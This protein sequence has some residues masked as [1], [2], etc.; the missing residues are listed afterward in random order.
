MAKNKNFAQPTSSKPAAAVVTPRPSTRATE[1]LLPTLEA[2]PRNRKIVLAIL[3]VCCLVAYIP[4]FE[5]GFVWDD[6]IY[7]VNN[8]MFKKVSWENFK[9]IWTI[10]EGFVLGNFHPLTITSNYLEYMLVGENAWLYHFNNTLLHIANSYLVYRVTE[11]ISKNFLVGAITGILFACHPLHV[12]SVVWAAERKDVLYTFFLL[13]SFRQYLKYTDHLAEKGLEWDIKHRDLWI[14]LALFVLSCLSK[15]MAVVLPVVLVMTDYFV[16]GRKQ[17]MKIGMEKAAFFGVALATGLVSIMAQR[18]A[19][20][21]ATKVLSAA[22]TGTERFFIIHYGVLQYWIKMILPVGLLPFYPYPQKPDNQLPSEF[23]GAFFIILMLVGAFWFFGRRNPLIAWSG[24][25]FAI[26]ILP[27]SQALPVGSAIAADRYFYVS[28]VGPLMLL[29]L[30]GNYLYRKASFRKSAPTVAAVV[31]LAFTFLS[32]RQATIWKDPLTLFPRVLEKYP[33][34]PLMVS[35]MGWYYFKE[36]DMKQAKYYFELTHDKGNFKTTDSHV[37]LGQIYFDEQNYAKTVEHF[38][39]AIKLKPEDFEMK[40]LRWMLATAYYYVGDLEKAKAAAEYS[41]KYIP[42]NPFAINVLGLIEVKKGNLAEAE[43][44]Y[45]QAIKANDKF[46]DPFVNMSVIYNQRGEHDKEIAILEKAVKIKDEKKTT[47]YKNLGV[48]YKAAGQW[49]KCIDVWK[50]GS[51]LDPK[52]GSFDYNIAQVYGQNQNEAEG[53]KFMISAVEKNDANA[54]FVVNQA[55]FQGMLQAK[56]PDLFNRLVQ[57][58][59]ARQAAAQQAQPTQ[60]ANT[61]AGTQPVGTPVQIP[62]TLK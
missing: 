56:Y 40:K 9:T 45:N 5:N 1:E 33:D 21:D 35:N 43:K 7:I 6:M 20:A 2:T 58:V 48:A 50:Q 42:N 26:V 29:G 14:S 57:L 22:Y 38:E 24:L 28:S 34:D 16:L 61:P 62:N 3:A 8:E 51:V 4:G 31:V 17:I 15:G 25:Y 59:Q 46:Q 13:L 37:A 41:L 30:L 23:Y 19:G 47:A 44:L 54:L 53:S 18:E 49:Q 36:K 39:G 32:F 12:E 27:V 55:G 10:P 60:P 52:D 11:K